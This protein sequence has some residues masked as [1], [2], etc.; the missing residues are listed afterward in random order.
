MLALGETHFNFLVSEFVSHYLTE[1]PHQG[2]GNRPLPDVGSPEPPRLS[3]PRAGVVC[4]QRL[5][6]LLKSYVR[7]ARVEGQPG[8][9]VVGRVRGVRRPPFGP[10]AAAQF[11]PFIHRRRPTHARPPTRYRSSPASNCR[12]NDF[13][14]DVIG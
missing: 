13:A 9:F 3:F 2:I 8:F 4:H 11:H 7:A 1:R 10:T 12:D 6:S 14:Q 5:G